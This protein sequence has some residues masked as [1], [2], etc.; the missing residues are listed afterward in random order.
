MQ[1]LRGEP[2]SCC[3]I[4]IH[5]FALYEAMTLKQYYRDC[6]MSHGLLIMMRMFFSKLI[7]TFFALSLLQTGPGLAD[8]VN[9]WEASTIH[10]PEKYFTD[11]SPRAIAVDSAGRPHIAYGGDKLYY[12]FL[13]GGSWKVQTVD[14]ARQTGSFAAVAVNPAGEVHISYYDRDNR[15]LRYA[16][17]T[18]GPWTKVTVDDSVD[19]GRYSAVALDTDNKAH[20]S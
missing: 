12:A 7:S 6:W 16:T 15:R 10:L 5:R 11:S 13:E 8:T 14:D 19:V 4:N 18:S 17:N 2:S 1:C 3:C 20:I 9:N